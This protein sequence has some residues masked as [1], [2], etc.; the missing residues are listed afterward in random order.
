MPPLVSLK[1]DRSRKIRSLQRLSKEKNYFELEEE[2]KSLIKPRI[3]DVEATLD[4]GT[5]LFRSR[6]GVSCSAMPLSSWGDERH[7]QP[8]SE[9]KIS[10]PSPSIASAGR[11]NRE[12]VS[13]LYMASDIKTAIAETRPHPGHY[14][15]Y[16]SFKALKNLVVADLSSIVVTDFTESDKRL[17]EYLLL[18]TLDELFSIP[19]T[20]EEKA[21][22]HLTQLLADCFRQLNFDAISYNSS[23]GMGNNYVIFDPENFSYVFNSGKVVKIRTL[24]YSYDNMLLM[25]KEDDYWTDQK[26]N[27]I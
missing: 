17:E 16:G 26:G 15:S 25:G 8:F 11:M 6:I 23:V 13:F 27:F 21:E 2:A 7:Y 4:K 3:Q 22:Y 14:C 1:N 12:G 9:S 5:I 19:V 24:K 10:A 20:P 18:K